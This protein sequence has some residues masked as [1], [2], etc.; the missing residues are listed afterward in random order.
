M[1]VKC[2]SAWGA[3]NEAR[4]P[5]ALRSA[6]GTGP[7]RCTSAIFYTDPLPPPPPPPLPPQAPDRKWMPYSQPLPGAQWPG[8]PKMEAL[9]TRPAGHGRR[10]ATA[11][12]GRDLA[13]AVGELRGS[14][15]A[16]S[17]PGERRPQPLL[18]RPPRV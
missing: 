10:L 18:L 3:G 1:C 17:G 13:G 15:R 6:A 14:P 9:A 7:S 5:Q 11:R 4:E 16:S 8:D 2:T 12:R